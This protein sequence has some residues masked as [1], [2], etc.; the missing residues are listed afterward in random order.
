MIEHTAK[1]VDP[2]AQP[3]AAL[4]AA[5]AGGVGV[6]FVTSNQALIIAL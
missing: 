5:L 6:V 2:K 1:A 4:L 3:Y